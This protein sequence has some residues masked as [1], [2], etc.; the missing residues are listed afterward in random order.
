MPDDQL[1]SGILLLS[2]AELRDPNFRR[3]VVLLCNHDTDGSFG[4]T[5][6]RPL[7]LLASETLDDF[8]ETE[9]GDSMPMYLGGPVDANTVHVL[10]R[11]GNL[12]TDS[13]EIVDGVWWGGDYDEIKSLLKQGRLDPNG[14]RFY[15]GYS[16]W[17]AG[18]LD[19]EMTSN[20]WYLS[21]GDAHTVF[22]EDAEKMWSRV[23]R[24]KGGDYAIVATF[25]Q[26]PQLN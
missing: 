1:R 7:D 10:H 23:L 3:T 16:G 13:T 5:L 20:A 11:Y 25:P 17:G 22:E 21:F 2:N 18:Q 14:I 26:D 6:N 19:E 8:T 24:K 9:L 12:I 4:L 15:L